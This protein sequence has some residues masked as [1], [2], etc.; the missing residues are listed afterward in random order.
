MRAE[1][2]IIYNLHGECERQVPAGNTVRAG[3]LVAHKRFVE[4]RIDQ[5]YRQHQ[6]GEIGDAVG[7][8][9]VHA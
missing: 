4:K 2:T 1:Q 3:I 5:N 9:G 7:E 8:I 6:P